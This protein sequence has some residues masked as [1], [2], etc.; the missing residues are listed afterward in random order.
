[1]DLVDEI[2]VLVLHILKRNITQDTGVIDQN[3]NSAKVLDG[4]V[5]DGLA[6]LDTIVIG[7]GLAAGPSNLF[8]D[9]IGSLQ[10]QFV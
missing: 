6:I 4:R 1:M 5:N 3:I 10:D 8:D 2:P 9:D 7:D